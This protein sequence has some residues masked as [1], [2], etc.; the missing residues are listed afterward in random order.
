MRCATESLA[1][2]ASTS[3]SWSAESWNAADGLGTG[4]SLMLQGSAFGISAETHPWLQRRW[5]T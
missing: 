5:G 4:S 2:A 1:S 3:R